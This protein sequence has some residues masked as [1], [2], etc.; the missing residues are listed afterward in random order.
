MWL[1]GLFIVTAA[2]YGIAA[3]LYLVHLARGSKAVER[4]AH[5]SLGA[6]VLAHVGFLAVDFARYGNS[7]FED[8]HGTLALLSLGTVIGFLLSV[9]RYPIT[10]LG[11]FIT[12][13]TL[14]LFLGSG[15]GRGVA[16][17]PPEVKTALLPV[18]IT[19]NVLG[20]MAFA[21]A[22]GASVAYVIQERMLRQK[23]IGGVFQRLP[24]LDV[25][26][27]VAFRSVT[28]GFPLLTAGV[29]TG[30]FWAVRLHD[31]LPAFSIAQTLGLLTW[32]VFAAVLVLRVAA[33]WRGRRAALGT[34]MGFVCALLVLV[35]YVVQARNGA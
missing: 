17:V 14:L 9:I 28:I 1:T 12:P 23:R 33:G 4:A 25:L 29:I 35:G 16:Q 24:P 6:A 20:L 7:P 10:V 22:F 31:G 13:V 27:A 3:G 32:F 18:H 26:D 11:A 8:I 21:V 2:L 5:V 19:M 15:L 34:I 30:A